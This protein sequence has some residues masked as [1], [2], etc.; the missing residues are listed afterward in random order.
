LPQDALPLVFFER[1]YWTESRR[2]NREAL[3][4]VLAISQL[5]LRFGGS[6]FGTE[7]LPTTKNRISNMTI[8][9]VDRSFRARRR[10]SFVVLAC[11]SVFLL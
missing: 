10:P 7:K 5:P 2:T 6:M 1:L 9:S 11:L 8:S 4:N 3:R